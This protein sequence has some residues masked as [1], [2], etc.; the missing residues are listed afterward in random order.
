M[1]KSLDLIKYSIFAGIFAVPFLVFIVS[2]SMFFP[3]I[4]GKNFSFRIIVEV[5]TALWLALTLFDARYK[6][7]KSWILAMLAIFVGVVAL[8]SIFGENL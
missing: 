1:Q 8:S 7:R 6:P 2:G 3:F 4:T 5:M